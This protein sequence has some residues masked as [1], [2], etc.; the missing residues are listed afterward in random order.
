MCF[1]NI[2]ILAVHLVDF[3]LSSLYNMTNYLLIMSTPKLFLVTAS[4][5]V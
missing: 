2:E 5:Y 4:M 3:V 1:I